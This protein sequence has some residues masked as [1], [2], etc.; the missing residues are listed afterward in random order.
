MAPVARP[1]ITDAFDDPP[2]ALAC[3]AL[4]L[5]EAELRLPDAL[6][7]PEAR[8]LPEDDEEARRLDALDL[9]RDWVDLLADLPFEAL[10]RF[11]FEALLRFVPLDPP[12]PDRLLE[13]LAREL[14]ALRVDCF[15]LLV[16]AWAM[17]PSLG[18]CPAPAE[19]LYPE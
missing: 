19:K 9:P 18:R 14:F 3:R 1:T 2:L 17:H 5:P 13:P 16:L 11:A 7:P 6:P 15:C 10:L 4:A 12:L 8:R